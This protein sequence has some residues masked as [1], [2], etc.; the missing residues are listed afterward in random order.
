M[1]DEVIR[2][3]TAKNNREQTTSEDV[4][5]WARGIKAQWV[6]VAILS[7]IT[8]SKKIDK[9]KMVQKTK[10][11]QDIETTHQAHHKHPCKYCGGSHAPKQCPA[12]GKMHAGCRKIG[13]FMKVC[14]SRRDQAVHEVEME[15]VPEPQEEEIETVSINSLYLNKNHSLITAHLETQVGKTTIEVSYKIDT[16]S[17]VNLMPLYI[18]KRFFK[19]MSKEQLKCSIKS[20]IKLRTYNGTHITQLGTCAVIIKFK[21][22]KKCCFF[23]VV[24]GNGQVLL[25]M[26]DAAVL[27]IINLNIDS[28]Q[29]EMVSSK[30]NRGQEIHTIAEG[31]TN[32]NKAGVIKHDAN[33]QNDQNTSNKSI[34]YFYS[35]ANTE[36]DRK[37]SN[38]ITQ[39]FMRHLTMFLL[40]LGASKAHSHY[41]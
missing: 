35:S 25:G 29:A 5:V 37:E 24:P 41:S 6:Q 3:L 18:F 15:M 36:A 30:T 32:R 33:G 22:F 19:D 17:E 26:P 10:G 40:V 38:A 34:N 13:H 23:F 31:C 11:R 1:L 20:N 39:K 27:N 14:R 7:D 28:I 21:N 9:V 12:Y 16:G 4:L 8:E 2:E